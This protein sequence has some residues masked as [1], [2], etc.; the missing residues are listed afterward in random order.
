MN[1][2]APDDDE[3]ERLE[4]AAMA[5]GLEQ[6]RRQMDALERTKAERERPPADDDEDGDTADGI[7]Q[8]EKRAFA[9]HVLKTLEEHRAEI[10]GVNFNGR[11]VDEMI[12]HLRERKRAADESEA[13]REKAEANYLDSVV[14]CAQTRGS[15]L[16]EVARWME[17]LE[18]C[19]EE[20]LS[21]YPFAQRLEIAELVAR[22]RGGARE[23]CLSELPIEERRQ[24]E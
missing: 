13:V 14:V 6:L 12:A 5:E 7:S 18:S 1:D 11:T 24:F 22:W 21:A 23:A 19:N 17:F 4:I 10:A 9:N 3:R 8:E 20:Q 16:M 15:A 2:D